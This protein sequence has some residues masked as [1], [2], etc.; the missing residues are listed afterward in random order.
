MSNEKGGFRVERSKHHD[1]F[2]LITPLFEFFALSLNDQIFSGKQLKCQGILIEY[3][4]YHNRY[5]MTSI[6]L[7]LVK[8]VPE[9][10]EILKRFKEQMKDRGDTQRSLASKIPCHAGQLSKALAGNS[11]PSANILI[12][13]AREGYDMNF[14]LRGEVSREESWAEEKKML[15]FHIDRLEDLL[16]K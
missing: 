7:L 9:L 2:I 5:L 13:I 16:K 6:K 12:G 8:K 10:L 14:I 1:Q 15:L 11:L 4:I 3:I